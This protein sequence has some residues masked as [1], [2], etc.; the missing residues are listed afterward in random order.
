MEDSLNLERLLAAQEPI[1]QQVLHELDIGVKTAD[2]IWFFFPQIAGLGRRDMA[3]RYAI[4]GRTEARSYLVHPVIGNRL[5]E[6]TKLMLGHSGQSAD[7]ILGAIDALKFHSSMTLFA[8]VG[9][10]VHVFDAALKAFFHGEPDE[11]T[12]EL[13]GTPEAGR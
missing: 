7:R 13:L 6:C 1:Y 8:A 3:R 4:S 5:R 2:R 10:E 12:I 11:R 9:P